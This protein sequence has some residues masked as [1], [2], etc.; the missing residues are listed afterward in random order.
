[1][2][3]GGTATFNY[4]VTVTHD[5]GTVSGV[6]V[7]GTISVFNPNVDGSV[8]IPV[9]ITA[10]TDQLSDGTS[11]TVTNGGPQNLTQLQTDFAYE[12]DL[13]ALPQGQLDNIATVA[14][15]TQTLAGGNVLTGATSSF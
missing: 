15:D 9:A 14:W 10:V 7:S 12:C 13:A 4:T 6:K 1:K 11:C 2:Q 8:T 3:I 5:A